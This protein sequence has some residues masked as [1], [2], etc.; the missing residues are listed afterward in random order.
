MSE[1]TSGAAAQLVAALIRAALAASL[2]SDFV[3][4]DPGCACGLKCSS[5]AIL[6]IKN[7]ATVLA[8]KSG[9]V[10]QHFPVAADRASAI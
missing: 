2:A 9:V 6:M 5:V 4:R 10:W 7:L 3:S 8:L 1:A